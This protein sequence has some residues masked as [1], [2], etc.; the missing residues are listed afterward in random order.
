MRL[1]GYA[2][3]QLLIYSWVASD[4]P[5]SV[6]ADLIR[7][8]AGEQTGTGEWGTAMNGLSDAARDGAW[9]Y[10]PARVVAPSDQSSWLLVGD[11]ILQGHW[12]YPDRA[13]SA[14][15]LAAVK[16]AQGGEAHVFFPSRW[17]ER[18]APHVP[19]APYMIDQ[20]GVNSPGKM[21]VS[22]LAFWRHAKANGVKYLLKTTIAPTTLQGAAT[23]SHADAQLDNAWLRDGAP[24]TADKTTALPTGTTDATAVRCD[25]IRP[26]GTIKRGT[27]NG[28]PIDAVSDL[29]LI[30]I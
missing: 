19:T 16:S 13:T 23:M 17:N 8:R 25:V 12:S 1:N 24:L 14:R 3:E 26:D 9:S 27:G 5:G 30:H 15:G 22:G 6:S 29:S 10:R 11:S 7:L 2:G 18:C 4:G 28:H 21:P 20:Y